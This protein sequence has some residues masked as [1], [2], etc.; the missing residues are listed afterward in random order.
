VPGSPGLEEGAEP[1][2]ADIGWRDHRGTG[3][4]E[5]LKSMIFLPGI[6]TNQ[7]LLAF[8]CFPATISFSFPKEMD[9]KHIEEDSH[10]C[11]SIE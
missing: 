4:K 2:R 1:D 6:R 11:L 3:K 5:C 8:S 9:F 10:G 7:V